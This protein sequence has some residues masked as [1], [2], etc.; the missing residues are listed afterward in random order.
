MRALC[1]GA[2]TASA[3]LI[4]EYSGSTSN[5]IGCTKTWRNEIYTFAN[6]EWATA[7]E[8]AQP[9]GYGVTIQNGDELLFIGGETTGGKATTDVISVTVENGAVVAK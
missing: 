1:P 3:Q 2:N 7:G 6:G 9:L 4:T 5:G 8:L